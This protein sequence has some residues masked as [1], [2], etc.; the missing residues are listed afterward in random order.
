MSSTSTLA[1]FVLTLALGAIAAGC[2][3]E[4]DDATPSAAEAADPALAGG[5][6]ET[7]AEELTSKSTFA[8]VGPLV[9]ANCG[10]C[11]AQFNGLAGIKADKTAMI[12]KISA[13]AMPKGNPGFKSTADGKKVL[14]WLRTGNDLK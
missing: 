5:A 8:V 1:S 14:K 9:A 11:H 13:G 4:A 12:A 10:G 3:A 6:A 7:T 2:A